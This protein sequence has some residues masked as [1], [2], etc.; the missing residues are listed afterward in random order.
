M[1]TMPK[2]AEIIQLLQRDDIDVLP[3]NP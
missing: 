3:R 1:E 2:K